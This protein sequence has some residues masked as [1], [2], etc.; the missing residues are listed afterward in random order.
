M[1]EGANFPTSLNS[2]DKF[3]TFIFCI[4]FFSNNL[5]K[6]FSFGG[7]MKVKKNKMNTKAKKINSQ[8]SHEWEDA[9]EN[10]DKFSYK[11]G[12]LYEKAKDRTKKFKSRK[13]EGM[14]LEQYF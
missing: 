5:E 14:D 1:N 7:K 10:M 2:E 13:Y 11:R 3:I 12:R 4:F 9:I 6:F 8:Y